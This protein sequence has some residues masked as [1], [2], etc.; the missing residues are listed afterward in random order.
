MKLD[1]LKKNVGWWMEIAHPA[2][3]LDDRFLSVEVS[4]SH[5]NTGTYFTQV[6]ECSIRRKR[7]SWSSLPKWPRPSDPNGFHR[8]P[9]DQLPVRLHSELLQ[10]F[11]KVYQ[12]VLQLRTL[13]H[14]LRDTQPTTKPG[15]SLAEIPLIS[16]DFKVKITLSEEIGNDE[17]RSTCPAGVRADKLTAPGHRK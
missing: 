12:R 6:A 5:R 8:H 10:P 11:C 15:L 4:T 13:R 16:D 17:S 9:F 3:H 14:C 7:T 1:R 2:C